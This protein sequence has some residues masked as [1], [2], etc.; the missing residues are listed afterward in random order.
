M[1]R[2]WKRNGQTLPLW[3]WIVEGIIIALVVR[4][5]RRLLRGFFRR[6]RYT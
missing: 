4:V 2:A 5:A 6:R 3:E 1:F